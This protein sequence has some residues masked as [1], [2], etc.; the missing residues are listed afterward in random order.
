MD[1]E[2]AALAQVE[3]DLLEPSLV[4]I[5]RDLCNGLLE[6]FDASKLKLINIGRI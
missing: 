3:D 1:F 2:F 6:A 5:H 4:L